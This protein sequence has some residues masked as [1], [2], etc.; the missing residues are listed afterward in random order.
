MAGA[1]VRVMQMEERHLEGVEALQTE[2]YPTMADY[3]KIT[4]KHA[5]RHLEL[6]RQGQTV[7]I[8]ESSSRV[9]GMNSGFLLSDFDFDNPD[10]SFQEVTSHLW[11]TSHDPCGEYYYGGDICVSPSYRKQGIGR[12]LYDS[13]KG[14][15]RELNKK[16]ILAGGMLTGLLKHRKSLGQ[17]EE[18]TVEEYV[19]K[20]RA[21]TLVDPSLTFQMKCGFQVRGLMKSYIED[22]SCCNSAALIYWE[23]PDYCG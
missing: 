12:K 6:F 9:V 1:R 16:G 10:H 20:V 11:Y 3:E 15:A 18:C 7:A 21:G 8:D 19:E 14:I 4:A 22:E 23:N 5:A 13:R 17:G 2:C